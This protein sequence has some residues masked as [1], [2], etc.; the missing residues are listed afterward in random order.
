MHIIEQHIL[1]KHGAE[2][3]EDAIIVTDAFIAV[4]DGSTSKSKLPKPEC[5][6]SQ[7]QI[8]AKC[9]CEYIQNCQHDVDIYSF[10]EGVTKSVY[11]QYCIHHRKMEM[12]HFVDHPEDRFTC[13]AIIY[14]ALRKE[15]WMIGDC[16]CMLIK[17]KAERPCYYDNPKPI[18]AVLASQRAERIKQILAEGRT[19]LSLRLNDEGREYIIPALR[20]STKR[21]NKDY[22]VID[23]F[24]IAMEKIKVISTT[25]A[26]EIILAS[27]GY[28][29]LFPTLSETEKFLRNILD[30]DPLLIGEF[31]ATKCWKPE[32]NSFDDRSYIR[33]TQ[34]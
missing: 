32:S 31:Q 34:E 13:S 17:S 10:C 15:I 21:Q 28:P 30:N 6:L 3:C 25:D 16:H 23:G 33:F 20:D 27:D 18:E 19:T 22:A 24:T 8:A 7:G 1:G 26:K 4:I 5:G 2:L 14:S 9:V 11:K 12:Q 29:K